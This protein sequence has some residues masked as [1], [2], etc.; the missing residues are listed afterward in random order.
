M[1]HGLEFLLAAFEAAFEV[2]DGAA[3]VFEVETHILAGGLVVRRLDPT[4]RPEVDFL[5]QA[6]VDGGE[7]LVHMGD[8]PSGDFLIVFGHE[9]AGR[10]GEGAMFL[11]GLNPGRSSVSVS[12]AG[13]AGAS[14]SRSRCGA[15]PAKVALPSGGTRTNWRR[16]ERTRPSP[17]FISWVSR[18]SRCWFHPIVSWV[19]EDGSLAEEV[20]VLLQQDIADGEHQ[21]VAGMEHAGEGEPGLSSGR[22]A[23]W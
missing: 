15:Q 5:G 4:I 13:R 14:G 19:H 6:F 16:L 9:F 20:G 3:G 17:D 22:T 7:G 8:A 18:K 11:A 10:K 1:A 12:S 23:S 21:R 2:G